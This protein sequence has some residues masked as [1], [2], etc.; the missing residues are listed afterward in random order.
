MRRAFYRAIANLLDLGKSGI[1]MTALIEKDG[2]LETYKALLDDGCLTLEDEVWRPF[3]EQAAAALPQGALPCMADVD[4]VRVFFEQVSPHQQLVICGGGHIAKP[5]A[6]IGALLDFDVTVIDDRPEFANR[7]RFP[8]AREVVCAPFEQALDTMERSD[9]MY[10]S[11]L[12][13]AICTTA[14]VCKGFWITGGL[15]IAV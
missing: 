10:M 11:L 8:T 4:G 9:E 2:C 5:L 13:T 3:W 6:E 12:R 7:E 14:A 15:L 1:L